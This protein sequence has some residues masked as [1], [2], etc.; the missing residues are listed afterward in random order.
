LKFLLQAQQRDLRELTTAT[1]KA[2]FKLLQAS[3]HALVIRKGNH[4]CQFPLAPDEKPRTFPTA[5]HVQKIAF[6]ELH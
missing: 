1:R 5:I 3:Q 2:A 4:L 6:A